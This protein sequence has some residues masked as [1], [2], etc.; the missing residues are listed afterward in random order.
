MSGKKKKIILHVELSAVDPS[1][2]ES[3]YRGFLE[4]NNWFD[5]DSLIRK[6]ADT[7][8]RMCPND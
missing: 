3:A 8:E 7:I 1:G 4:T 6:L 2:R 5:A